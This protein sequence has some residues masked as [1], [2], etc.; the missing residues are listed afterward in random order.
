MG[1]ATR[2]LQTHRTGSHLPA[3]HLTTLLTGTAAQRSASAAARSAVGCM[4]LLGGTHWFVRACF[5]LAD[6]DAVERRLA[7][8]SPRQRRPARRGMHSTVL[9]LA[10]LSHR[11]QGVEAGRS[12]TTRRADTSPHPLRPPIVAP[13]GWRDA[14]LYSWCPNT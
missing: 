7:G 2:L 6:R 9:A 12:S 5:T 10:A 4:P 14:P 1:D 3:L 11:S 13:L 8:W